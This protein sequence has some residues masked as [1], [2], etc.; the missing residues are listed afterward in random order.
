[1]NVINIESWAVNPITVLGKVKWFDPQKGYGFITVPNI[2]EDILIHANSVLGFGQSSISQNA[3]IECMVE[4][5]AGRFRVTEIIRYEPVELENDLPDQIVFQPAR[6]K[7]FCTKKQ[8]G[9]AV[10][11]EAPG[12]IFIGHHVLSA[13]G[14]TH[15]DQ[16]E[17]IAIAMQQTDSGLIAVKI[18]PWR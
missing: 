2:P 7:W 15:L 5:N 8:Y 11:F 9:F 14:L 3:S 10:A 6:T 4:N 18:S 1:M 12:D 16:G 17:A 13:A